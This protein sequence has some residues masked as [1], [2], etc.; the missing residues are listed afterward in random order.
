MYMYTMYM[1]Q[2]SGKILSYTISEKCK[3]SLFLPEII[4]AF[5][6]F[7]QWTYAYRLLY[8]PENTN[9]TLCSSGGAKIKGINSGIY[10]IQ[11]H[12]L[13]NIY[14]FQ[15]VVA[16]FLENIFQEA[17]VIKI[18]NSGYTPASLL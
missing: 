3:L 10:S 14:N 16:N 1:Y 15:E 6:H 12:F 5:K 9:K 18:K 17:L 7:L 2:A 13:E 4:A 8:I 11:G